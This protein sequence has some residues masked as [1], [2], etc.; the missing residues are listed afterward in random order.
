MDRSSRHCSVLS[1][2]IAGL[3]AVVARGNSAPVPQAKGK[4]AIRIVGCSEH[5]QSLKRGVGANHL[6]AADFRVLAPGVS[7]YYNWHFEP[8]QAGVPPRDV[9]IAF[10]PMSWGDRPESL[11]GLERYLAAGHKPRQILAINEPNLRGQSFLPPRQAATL[12]GKIK[13]IADRYHIP[14]TGPQMAIGSAPADSIAA[15]DPIENKELRYTFMVPYLKAFLY[16]TDSARSEV[17]SLGIHPYENAGGLIALTELTHKTFRRPVWI[18]EFNPSTEALSDAEM[19]AYVIQVTDYMERTPFVAGYA[20]FKERFEGHPKASLLA[21]ET[22]KLTP[23][24]AAYVSM[25]IHDADLY[26]RIPGRLQAENY[27]SMDKMDIQPTTDDSGLADM[28]SSGRDAGTDYNLQVDKAGRYALDFRL[29]GLPGKISV[30][31]GKL[32]LAEVNVRPVADK[33][34]TVTALVRLPAGPQ[35][36]RIRYESKGLHI[37]W[38][39]FTNSSLKKQ[40]ELEDR[41]SMR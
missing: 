22:G 39:E 40:R 21:Q 4:H 1:L 28:I 27:V 37:N 19:L 8:G 35:T 12:Y 17:S 15:M 33:W 7:W 11:A 6:E 3:V 29:A 16:Y 34:E 25:P 38:I 13:T 23:W 24:G 36:L 14:V 32:L 41:K 5:V 26:Y 30:F 20:F 18:T 2:C 31:N 9:P 10:L